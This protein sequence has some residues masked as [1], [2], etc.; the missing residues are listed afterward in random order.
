MLFISEKF[1]LREA[2]LEGNASF[3]R[4]VEN[5]PLRYTKYEGGL[6]VVKIAVSLEGVEYIR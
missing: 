4:C 3:D 1:L 5:Y 6:F 2:L